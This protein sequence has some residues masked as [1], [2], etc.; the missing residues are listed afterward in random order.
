MLTQLHPLQNCLVRIYFNHSIYPDIPCGAGVVIDDEKFL[1]CGH[2]IK[3]SLGLSS[4]FPDVP[5]QPVSIDFPL[6]KNSKRI[7]AKVVFWDNEYDIAGLKFLEKI[8]NEIAPIFLYKTENLR[9]NPVSA[10]GFPS[11][12]PNGTWAKG[13]LRGPVD[14]GWIEIV[15]P[16]STGHFVQQGFSGSPVWDESLERCIGIVVAADKAEAY[17]TSYLIPAILIG[18]RWK[19]LPIKTID[20]KTNTDQRRDLPSLLPYQ[21]NH[22]YQKKLLEELCENSKSILPRPVIAIVHGNSDQAQDMFLKRLCWEF[23]PR[24]INSQPPAQNFHLRWPSEINSVKNLSKALTKSL[25]EIFS[26]NQT[27]SCQDIQDKLAIDPRTIV[28]DT[29]LTTNNP[30]KYNGDILKGFLDYWQN[31]PDLQPHQNLFIFLF[32]NY[33]ISEKHSI[34]SFTYMIRKRQVLSQ[35]SHCNFQQ[36]RRIIG[37][38]LPE[39]KG[40]LQSDVEEWARTYARDYLDDDITVTL[41]KIRKLYDTHEKE[42]RIP[43]EILASYLKE[44]LKAGSNLEE[45]IA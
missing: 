17:R 1:T 21:V 15:D 5:D 12:Y 8:P 40:I 29:V 11:K 25:G 18:D 20:Q 7:T 10:C 26:Y 9:N 23:I 33:R 28:I 19:E 14:T 44:F 34:K 37:T 2:V 32:L 24:I 13:E 27:A 43:M 45:V 30:G 41:Y 22:W 4:D 36:Y 16:Q 38:V 42:Q 39:L 31:W 6:V 35:I 3:A